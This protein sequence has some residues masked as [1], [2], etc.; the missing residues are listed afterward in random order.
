MALETSIFGSINGKEVLLYTIRNK[1]GLTLKLSSYGACITSLCVPDRKGNIE[2]VV[3]GYDN[4]DQYTQAH[5]YFGSIIGRYAN[6]IGGGKLSIDKQTFQ[7]SKNENENHL[8][9]G[10]KGFDKVIWNGEIIIRD[11][12][13]GVKLTYL[14]VDGEEGYPGNL[15]CEIEIGLTDKNEVIIHYR[16]TT[17]QPTIVNLTHHGYFNLKDG[18]KT[19]ALDHSL[20][21]NADKYTPLGSSSVPSGKLRELPAELDFRVASIISK[22]MEASSLATTGYDHNYVINRLKKEMVLAAILADPVSG[23]KMEVY[24]T[25][26]G[27][28]FYTAHGLNCENGKNGVHYGSSH[29]VCLET[30]HFPDSP[31]HNNFPNTTLRPEESYDEKVIY[32]FGLED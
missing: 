8:H 17:D 26:P 22:K 1:N 23:R 30:Q 21:L 6:R 18:G 10:F 4:L 19:S 28:Q 31:N 11:G 16:C 7:L 32:K 14:S 29:G 25:Q 3:L 5:P 12:F 27:I 24:T 15:S 20:L 9:G 13:E 2:D